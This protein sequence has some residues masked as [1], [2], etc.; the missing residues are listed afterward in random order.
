MSAYSIETG[1]LAAPILFACLDALQN[2]N[3]F[4]NYESPGSAAPRSVLRRVRGT[5]Q[6]N[7][8]WPI[9]DR[10]KELRL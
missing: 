8:I 9:S 5:G 6:P 10:M 1:A 3:K 2:H 7:P 4:K